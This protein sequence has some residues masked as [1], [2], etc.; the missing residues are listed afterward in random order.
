MKITQRVSAQRTETGNDRN[1]KLPPN[2]PLKIAKIALN[3]LSKMDED[4]S[5]VEVNFIPLLIYTLNL[6]TLVNCIQLY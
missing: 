5:D 6:S 2:F 4:E 1:R 3:S